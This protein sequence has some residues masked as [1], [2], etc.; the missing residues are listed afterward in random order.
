MIHPIALA[1]YKKE[2][3]ERFLESIDDRDSMHD[4]WEEW[5]ESYIKLKRNLISQGFL[6][7]DFVVNI[8]ELINYCKIRGIRNNGK[9]RSQF[10]AER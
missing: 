9:A 6:V 2:D 5:H 10:V 7:V 4:T 1:Y 3:W 8:D